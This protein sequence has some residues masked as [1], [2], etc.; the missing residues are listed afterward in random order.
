[1]SR[2]ILY[3][4]DTRLD[5]AAGYLAGVMTH[6]GLEFD[7]LASDESLMPAVA[8]ANHGVYVISDYPVNRWNPEAFEIVLRRVREGAGLVMIGGWESYHGLAGE[9]HQS[10][11]AE[12]LP[13]RMESS[14][15]RVNRAQ[16]C[17]VMPER[18][19]AIVD[20]LPWQNPPTV[21]GYNRVAPAEDAEVLLTLRPLDIRAGRDGHLG[22]TTLPPEPLL[23]T[24]TYGNG[25]T[26]A[27]AT[28]VAPHWVGTWVDW[29]EQRISARAEGADDIEV[30]CDYAEFFTRLL[31]WALG[32]IG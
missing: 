3:A 1:M 19:H 10:P 16:P 15:D 5:A 14:D 27:L 11:L 13:V 2:R 8:D 9:Y 28:D 31:R 6:A 18:E 29:G 21:G 24:G 7:Y 30:G 22:F 25:R 4:G 12:V 20:G 26:A 17:V 23:V 32:E